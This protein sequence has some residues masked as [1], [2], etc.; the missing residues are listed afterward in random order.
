MIGWETYWRLEGYEPSLE[1]TAELW[2]RQRDKVGT[3]KT[4]EVVYTGSSRITFGFDLDVWQQYNGG[5]RPISL[6]KVGT[7]PRPFLH[8]VANDPDFRGLL[9]CGVTE[10]LF[11]TPDQAPPA[12]D[13]IKYLDHYKNRPLTSRSEYLLS[14]P[15]QSAMASINKEDLNL[16]TLI[17]QRWLPLPDRKN[18]YLLP[19]WPPYFGRITSDRRYHMWSRCETDPVLQEKIQQIWLPWFHLAPPF[20]GEGLDHLIASVSED[21]KKIRD[22]GGRVLF[23]RLPSSGKLREI[24]RELWPREAYWDRLLEETGAE[25]VHFEDYPQLNQFDCPEWSHLTRGDAVIFTRNL[26]S[27]LKD[28][29]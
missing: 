24:E 26:I 3:G 5:P 1:E 17:Y 2:A 15:V 20:G 8:D 28:Q 7:N 21:V 4:D 12:W 23:V 22:R 11:F 25:G 16:A 10:V 29:S 19:D 27:V 9:I 6:P 14:M 13:A 18:A